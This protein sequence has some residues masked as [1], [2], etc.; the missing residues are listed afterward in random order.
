MNEKE[1]NESK[2]LLTCFLSRM[3]NNE[4]PNPNRSEG[5]GGS[6]RKRERG[7]Y[8]DDTTTTSIYVDRYQHNS[9]NY[10]APYH[11]TA[12]PMLKKVKDNDKLCSQEK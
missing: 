10:G 7:A 8:Y 11:Y 6:G 5:G 4:K 2:S 9:N 12:A 1:K 3:D